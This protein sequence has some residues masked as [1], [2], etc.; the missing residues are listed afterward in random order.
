MSIIEEMAKEA[1]RTFAAM[2]ADWSWLG[3][4]FAA[5]IFVAIVTLMLLNK[6]EHPKKEDSNHGPNY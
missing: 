3:P 1:E 6:W 5:C 2:Q 4:I